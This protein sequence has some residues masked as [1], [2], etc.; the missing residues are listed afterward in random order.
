M[1]FKT[2]FTVTAGTRSKWQT[3]WTQIRTDIL[4]VQIWVQ[5]C[6]QRLWISRWQNSPMAG[7]LTFEF[8]LLFLKTLKIERKRVSLTSTARL[9]VNSLYA[10]DH[11]AQLLASLIADPW[12]WVHSQPDPNFGGDF[13]RS[14][15]LNPSSTDSRRVVVNHCTKYWY[16]RLIYC[17]WNAWFR[18]NDSLDM[19]IY[20][21][22]LG[23]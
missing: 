4:S 16:N 7:K 18:L 15:I 9:V 23:R 21:C 2:S 3:A 1:I 11:I 6:L 10:S 14:D 8:G 22:W 5:F 20:S 13:L 17:P 12:V 19:T